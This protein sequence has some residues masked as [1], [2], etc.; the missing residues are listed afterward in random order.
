MVG[1]GRQRR[2]GDFGY[3]KARRLEAADSVV[4]RIAMIDFKGHEK[5]RRWRATRR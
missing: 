2:H 4:L 5:R 1:I 3:I